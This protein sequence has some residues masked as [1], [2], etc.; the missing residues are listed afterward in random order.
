MWQLIPEQK[1][2]CKA[3]CLCASGLDISEVLRRTIETA[4]SAPVEFFAL[5]PQTQC[6]NFGQELLSYETRIFPHSE[7]G[8]MGPDR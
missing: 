5:R 3:E 6:A 4:A 1:Q 8:N 2:R 7:Q